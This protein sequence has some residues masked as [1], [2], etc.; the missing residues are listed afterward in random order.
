MVRPG[1]WRR[2]VLQE[3]YVT[4]SK[5]KPNSMICYCVAMF[6][7]NK[8]A[9][10]YLH[11]FFARIVFAWDIPKNLI[12]LL[13]NRRSRQYYIILYHIVPHTPDRRMRGSA[14]QSLD[15]VC[16]I[17]SRREVC[18]REGVR[19]R[20]GARLRSAGDRRF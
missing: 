3:C 13:S 20:E 19:G 11:V 6:W 18:Y 14:L 17:A 2:E 4:L 7:S 10:S 1:S 8:S 12:I 9:N 15:V 5:I 16:C